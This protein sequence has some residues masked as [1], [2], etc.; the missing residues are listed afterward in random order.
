MAIIR[1]SRRGWEALKAKRRVP[2]NKMKCYEDR[3][4][5]IS[6]LGYAAYQEY[7]K[8]DDWKVIRNRKLAKCPDCILCEGKATQVHH[9]DYSYETILGLLDY[10]LVQMCGECHGKIEFAG[11]R[12]RTVRE[13]TGELYRLAAMTDRGKRW[14]EWTN[15]QKDIYKHKKKS[16]KNKK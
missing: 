9:L 14:I 10:R 8:S 2:K 11:T 4:Q 7:L 3:G 16:R 5:R 13:A 12:K 15:H 1:G 6:D